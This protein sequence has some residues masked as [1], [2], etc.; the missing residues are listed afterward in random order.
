MRFEQTE[1][2]GVVTIELEEHRDERG[3]FARI[4]CREELAA[5]G[6]STELEQCS[7]SRNTRAGTLRGLHFQRPP[8]EEAKIV[9]CTRGAIFDVAVDVRRESPTRGRWV[10]VELDAGSGQA[11]YLPEGVAHGFQ[12]LVDDSEVMYL[13]STAYVPDA[14]AGVRWDDPDLAIAWPDTEMRTISD[15]DRELPLFA[16]L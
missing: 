14:A 11:L 13:I 2:P 6:L 1:L 3:S 16:D 15:R 9:R 8:H 7:I 10:G 5:A 4:W 12:T